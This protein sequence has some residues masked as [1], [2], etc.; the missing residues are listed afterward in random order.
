MRRISLRPSESESQIKCCTMNRQTRTGGSTVIMVKASIHYYHVPLPPLTQLE[1]TVLRLPRVL[2][3]ILL[4]PA[5]KLPTTS[6]PF[7]Q[8]IVIWPA[9]WIASIPL[10][11]AFWQPQTEG[12]Y[13]SLSAETIFKLIAQPYSTYYPVLREVITDVPDIAIDNGYV[14]P[15]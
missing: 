6:R 1:A 12:N 2:G 13:T 15:V 7:S 8:P 9:T 10:L 3:G 11:V 14:C 5:Y 4:V